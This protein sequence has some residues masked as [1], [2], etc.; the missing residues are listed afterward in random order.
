ALKH[1]LVREYVE[2]LG[3]GE[4]G[5]AF[6]LD[7]GEG[8]RDLENLGGLGETDDVV[9]ERLA[10]DRLHPKCHLRLVID[11]D[12]L[13]VLRCKDFELRIGHGKSPM[14][15]PSAEGGRPVGGDGPAAFDSGYGGG[16]P[17]QTARLCCRLQA[18]PTFSVSTR[19]DLQPRS[20]TR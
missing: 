12:D 2:Q 19:D 10:I 11:E 13:R 9:L 17:Y 8:R 15:G 1:R 18:R 14:I 7:R 4:A 3:I 20:T 16:H 6:G 5:K